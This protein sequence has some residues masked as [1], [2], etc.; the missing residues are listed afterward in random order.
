MGLYRQDGTRITRAGFPAATLDDP[1]VRVTEDVYVTEPYGRGDG[2]PEGSKRFLLYQ[3]G[4]VTLRSTIDRLFTAAT[5]ATISPATGP[6][7]GGS[8]ITINGAHLDGVSAVTFGGAAGT[9]LQV[10][11]A[12]ELTVKSPPGQA[13]AVTVELA[14]DS[15]PITLADGFTYEAPAGG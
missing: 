5:V 6:A 4:T 13:G 7:E 3:A 8:I 15:D 1:P 14:D 10:R 9:D 2:R 12:T 11:S